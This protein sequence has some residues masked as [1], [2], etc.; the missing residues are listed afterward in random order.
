[1]ITLDL[2]FCALLWPK[3]LCKRE[4]K[5]MEERG[6]GSFLIYFR[7]GKCFLLQTP[8]KSHSSSHIW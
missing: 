1:M 7:I 2:N 8:A 6:K 5:E 3:H 4:R